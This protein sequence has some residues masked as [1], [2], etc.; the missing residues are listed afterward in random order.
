MTPQCASCGQELQPRDRI[1]CLDCY[2]AL[3]ENDGDRYTYVDTQSERLRALIMAD[4][5][6]HPLPSHV[7]YPPAQADG[8]ALAGQDITEDGE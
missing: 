1:V 7:A 6:W 3:F 8:A 2:G 4:D 5:S